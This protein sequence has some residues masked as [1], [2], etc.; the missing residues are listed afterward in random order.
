MHPKIQIESKND[1]V[2][3][4]KEIESASHM[5]I[6]QIVESSPQLETLVQERINQVLPIYSCFKVKSGYQTCLN[7][8][9][10]IFR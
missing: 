3:L 5:S 1:I 6:A 4:Q 10:I 9:Q 8:L 7:Q 2:F